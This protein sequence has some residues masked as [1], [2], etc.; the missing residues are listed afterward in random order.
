M[1]RDPTSTDNESTA[2]MRFLGYPM[3]THLGPTDPVRGRVSDRELIR[4]IDDQVHAEI[5]L[6][7][8]PQRM[9][10]PDTSERQDVP[11]QPRPET[12]LSM[13]DLRAGIAQLPDEDRRCMEKIL[14]DGAGMM[15]RLEAI[16]HRNGRP[17]SAA[18]AMRQIFQPATH[19]W[20]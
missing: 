3:T 12:T 2:P 13:E 10:Q 1:T 16:M 17:S 20:T 11:T 4:A 9:L 14:T 8:D 15:T 7:Q 6:T 18:V 19:A 5:R